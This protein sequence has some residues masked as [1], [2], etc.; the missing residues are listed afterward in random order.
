[1]GD[2]YY[3]QDMGPVLDG[4][5]ARK[6]SASIYHPVELK[7][8]SNVKKTS[9]FAWLTRDRKLAQRNDSNRQDDGHTSHFAIHDCSGMTVSL[10]QTLGPIFG[11]KVATA[12]LG[13]VYAATM[14]T[15]LRTGRNIPGERP[16]TSI[17]PVIVTSD[18]R[19]VMVL[20][21]AGGIR[22]PSAIVQVISRVIDRGMPLEAAI[23]APRVHPMSSIDANNVRH[24]HLMGMEIERTAN[25]W[26]KSALRQWK[27]AKFNVDEIEGSGKFGRVYAALAVGNRLQGFADPDGEGTSS[28][29]VTCGPV[30]G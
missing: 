2:D 26:S 9:D 21:A 16:R 19:V 17:A 30:E 1:M 25:G 15:Y 4:T 3:E 23:A 12:E 22:I 8:A 27:S 6:H 13:I 29:A 20:G 18:N 28:R 24:V 5:W 11:A 14:G 7:S 10:T